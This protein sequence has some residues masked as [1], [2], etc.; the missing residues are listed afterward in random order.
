MNEADLSTQVQERHVGEDCERDAAAVAR[1]RSYALADWRG[2]N[3]ATC[4]RASLPPRWPTTYASRRNGGTRRKHLT[5]V[6]C[7]AIFYDA[8]PAS[9]QSQ[10]SSDTDGAITTRVSSGD[11]LAS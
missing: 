6:R 11:A 7:G 3:G 4:Q 1:S 9:T 5:V 8:L 2:G 10:P